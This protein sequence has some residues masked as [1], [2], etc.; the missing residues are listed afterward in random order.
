M[1]P[2]LADDIWRFGRDDADVFSSI[3]SGRPQ[4]MPAWRGVLTDDR[5]WKVIAYVRTLQADRTAAAGARVPH[6]RIN[7][8]AP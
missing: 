3:Y 4:G 5:I 7:I 2:P 6:H 1:G 8:A